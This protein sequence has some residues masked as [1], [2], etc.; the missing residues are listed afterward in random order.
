MK[1]TINKDEIRIHG[2]RQ[3]DLIIRIHT[4]KDLDRFIISLCYDGFEHGCLPMIE[5]AG[6]HIVVQNNMDRGRNLLR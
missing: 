2:E 6:G 5:V 1:I 4:D 3:V